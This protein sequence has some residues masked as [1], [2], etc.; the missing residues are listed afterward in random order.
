MT[1]INS[2]LYTVTGPKKKTIY[3]YTIEY[4]FAK[5]D[6][7]YNEISHDFQISMK[8]KKKWQY[9]NLNS[10]IIEL[11]KA[12]IDIS[13]SKLE[14]LIKSELIAKY[15]PIREYF[16]SLRSWDNVDHIGKLASNVPLYDNEA[17]VYHF[18]KWMEYDDDITVSAPLLDYFK[19]MNSP[20]N[21]Q[22]GYG[23]YLTS[24]FKD[25]SNQGADQLSMWW[26]N[27]NLR[28]FRNLTGITEGPEDR[29]MVLMGNGHA[30]V[31]RQLI[32]A[33]PEYDF[34]EFDSL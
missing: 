18:K 19:Y 9:I 21:H 3:D 31:L 32:E 23:L 26:Y 10:L 24:W 22:Y 7:Y 11:I 4:L 5:Y 27:R 20:V 17:F 1:A 28:I 34:V 16:E 14:I 2:Q 8:G 15:N 25:K 6:I 30:A 29:I 12:G 13:T 33:S